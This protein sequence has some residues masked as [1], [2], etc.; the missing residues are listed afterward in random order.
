M[1]ASRKPSLPAR[2]IV[3]HALI[4]GLLLVFAALTLMPFVWMVTSALKNRVDF[5]SSVFLP[6]GSGFLGVAWD[7]L[8]LANFHRLLV[9]LPIPRAMLNSFFLA[10]VHSVVAT[11]FCAM[12]GYGLSKF[13][14]RGREWLVTVVLA[15]IVIPAPLLLA[16]G[17]EMIYHLGLL[18]TYAGFL[19]PG[20]APAFGVFLF[21]QA[22]LNSVPGELIESARLDGCG[23]IRI[24]FQLVLPLVRPMIGAFMILSFLGVWNNFVGPQII[25]QSADRQPL[26]VAMN[27]LK[28]IYGTDYGLVMAGTLFSIA[29][30]ICLFL[31]L[32]KEFIT[33]LTSGAVK[34]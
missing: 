34:G 19:L 14:F 16:P 8:T 17:F 23:E 24:F 2:Q 20:F 11:L 6:R 30:I 22:M 28:G 7:R 3:A 10:S 4:Y 21:R 1:N 29:P 27:N 18:D 15:A 5:F 31:L 25:L 26:A 13:S 9:E 12:G 33:G 32:Q